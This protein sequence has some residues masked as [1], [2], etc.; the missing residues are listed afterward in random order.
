VKLSAKN[1]YLPFGV[2]IDRVA[3]QKIMVNLWPL[4]KEQ[5]A[6]QPFPDQQRGF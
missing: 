1:I 2:K 4:P 6:D 3:P 5:D